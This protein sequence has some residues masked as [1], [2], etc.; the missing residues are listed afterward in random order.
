MQLSSSQTSN[1]WRRRQHRFRPPANVTACSPLQ[2]HSTYSVLSLGSSRSSTAVHS[3][4]WSCPWFMYSAAFDLKHLS[5]FRTSSLIRRRFSFPHWEEQSVVAPFILA[6][7]IHYLLALRA[8]LC[9]YP[10]CS[11]LSYIITSCKLRSVGALQCALVRWKKHH[12]LDMQRRF[13]ME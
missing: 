5:S 12:G 13:Y 10:H 6:L 8:S 4:S 2:R 7:V 9:A 11:L 1:L 3:A